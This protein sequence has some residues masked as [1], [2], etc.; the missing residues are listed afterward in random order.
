M[1][2]YQRSTCSEF[3]KFSYFFFFLLFF[4]DFHLMM[5]H[6]NIVKISE[7]INIWN[8]LKSCLK[9]TYPFDFCKICNHFYNGKKLRVSFLCFFLI[10]IEYFLCIGNYKMYQC[11]VLPRLLFGLETIFLSK[12]HIK[13]LTDFIWTHYENFRLSQIEH[14]LQQYSFY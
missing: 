7:K 6:N 1:Y 11:Y 5:F 10:P 13:M 9:V 3:L 14:R 2:V 8:L 12:K 4:A